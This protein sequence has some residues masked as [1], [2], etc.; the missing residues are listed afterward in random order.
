MRIAAVITCFRHRSH[1]NVILENFL[2]PYLFNWRK[3]E[4]DCQIVSMDVDQHLKS[5]MAR[6][7]A[8]QYGIR[9]YPTI[10]D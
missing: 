3:I 8:R 1:A 9:I 10:H 7:V 2:E 6:K 4:P 5:D